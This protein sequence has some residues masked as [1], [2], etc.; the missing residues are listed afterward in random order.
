ML[1]IVAQTR[2]TFFLFVINVNCENKNKKLVHGFSTCH[3]RPTPRI[4]KL[5]LLNS[6]TSSLI[7]RAL[8]KIFTYHNGRENSIVGYKGSKSKKEVNRR[9]LPTYL[10][11]ESNSRFCVGSTLSL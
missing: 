11:N 9:N 2:N 1:E 3:Q 5:N 8:F 4:Y 6:P 7:D 10:K